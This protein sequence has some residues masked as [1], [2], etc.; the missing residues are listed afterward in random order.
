MFI[1]SQAEDDNHDARQ[2]LSSLY[3]NFLL[4]VTVLHNF[5]ALPCTVTLGIAVLVWW[6][7]G[8]RGVVLGEERGPSII[9]TPP[10]MASTRKV[11]RRISRQ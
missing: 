9:A 3:I 7:G 4:L 8:V 1:L 11:F 5:K 6:K 10:H 2:R